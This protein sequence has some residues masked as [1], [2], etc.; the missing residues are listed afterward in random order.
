MNNNNNN[1]VVNIVDISVHTPLETV[2][3][4]IIVLTVKKWRHSMCYGTFD[5]CDEWNHSFLGGL[6]SKE[7]RYC[8]DADVRSVWFTAGRST[9]NMAS[10]R[11]H[12]C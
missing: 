10:Q 5:A 9:G 11:E 6:D 1:S 8:S 4:T 7:E 12:S 2:K 3:T